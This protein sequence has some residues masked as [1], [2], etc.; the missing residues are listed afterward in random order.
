MK[1][2]RTIHRQLTGILGYDCEKKPIRA[3]DLVEPA[4]GV[5]VAPSG[6]CQMTVLRLP[7][8]DDRMNDDSVP[9][10]VCANPEGV[11]IGVRNWYAIRK[12]PQGEQDARWENVERITGWKPMEVEA[13]QEV[14]T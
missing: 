14:P 3:G 1:I 10:V 13:D 6:K 11:T 12:V 7:L 2:I 4:P 9:A 5:S 8:K